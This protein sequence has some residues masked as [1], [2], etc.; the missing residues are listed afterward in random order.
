MSE[1]KKGNGLVYKNHP[2]RRVDN[3]IYYG[4]MADKYIVLLQI[5]D[6]KK[7]Q[8]MDVA[9]RVSVQLQ[10]TDPDLKSRDRVVKKSEK[11]SLYAAMDV[12]CIWLERALAGQ[13]PVPYQPQKRT[14]YLLATGPREAI[15]SWGGLS[16]T[17]HWVWRW[18]DWIDRRFMSQYHSRETI[19][20]GQGT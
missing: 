2:L 18:K 20:S 16:A 11:D 4:S 10:M 5:L 19:M 9:T 14:L 3:L 17:G 15:L 1:V 8:D 12:G 13:A 7:E 6:T